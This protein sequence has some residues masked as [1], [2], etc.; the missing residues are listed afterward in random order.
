MPDDPLNLRI[1]RALFGWEWCDDSQSW[2]PPAW[3][4]RDASARHDAVPRWRGAL[5]VVRATHA[6]R[7]H[8][9]RAPPSRRCTSCNARAG[10]Q[11]WTRGWGLK[12]S[13]P[14]RWGVSGRLVE[15]EGGGHPACRC[16]GHKHRST[17]GKRLAKMQVFLWSGRYGDRCLYY[18]SL[19][20]GG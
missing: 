4:T 20:E 5:F 8:A 10:R 7:W 18:R 9:Q 12:P 14:S 19:N 17:G 2:G 1:V 15:A 13:A 16:A 6:S 3:P 11:S